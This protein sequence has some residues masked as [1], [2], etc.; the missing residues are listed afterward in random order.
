MSADKMF[1]VLKLKDNSMTL[2]DGS[3]LP[4]YQFE[5]RR[6]RD[7]TS[8]LSKGFGDGDFAIM[9]GKAL[10]L[11]PF[12]MEAKAYMDAMLWRWKSESKTNL[13]HVFNAEFFDKHSLC[14]QKLQG[15][16][17]IVTALTKFIND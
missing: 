11:Y 15:S 16:L 13:E 9:L 8:V 6:D 12:D 5:Q 1:D 17:R 4:Q 2:V 14:N 7:V 3:E 10:A